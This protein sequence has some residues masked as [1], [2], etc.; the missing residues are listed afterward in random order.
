MTSS[1]T[2]S[3]K[4]RA[5]EMVV[6]DQQMSLLDDADALS[7]RWN[8]EV[9]SKIGSSRETKS[10]SLKQQQLLWGGRGKGGRGIGRNTIQRRDIILPDITLEYISDDVSGAVGSRTLLDGA[11]LKL[12]SGGDR[13]Y[14]LVGRNGC[15]KSTL[16]RRMHAKKIPGFVNL[17]LQSMYIPQEVF[18]YGDHES[19]NGSDNGGDSGQD[20]EDEKE[21]ITPLDVV[22]R[23][24]K[25]NQQ[26]S[27]G[28][29]EKRIET[30]EQELETLMGGNTDDNNDNDDNVD[31][32]D[33]NHEEEIERI[34]NEI[35]MLEDQLNT[36]DGGTEE[37]LD[38]EYHQK[39]SQVLSCFGI[40]EDQQKTSMNYLSG[41]Q[42]KKVLLA[43]TLFCDID[44]LLLDEPTNHLDMQGIV[45]L[46]ALIQ[47]MI[48]RK[49]I[50]VLV[51]HDVALINSVATD[52]IHFANQTLTYYK[53]N[54]TDFLL[55]KNQHDLH[56]VHQQN[57]LNKQRQSMIKTIDNLKKQSIGSKGSGSKKIRRAMNERKKKLERHGVEKDENGHRRTVQSA[58]GIKTASI[59]SLDA[60]TRKH[61]K[62]YSQLIKRSDLSIAPVPE[63]EVQF[64]FKNI[65]C[66]WYEPLVSILD[67]GHGYPDGNQNEA[68]P[69]LRMLF[70]SVDLR[71]DEK[72]TTC[73][74]GENQ[75]GKTTLI[76]LISGEMQPTEGKVQFPSP[77]PTICYFDQH[78]ADNLIV[79]GVTKYGS[80]TSSISLLMSMYPKKTEQDVRGELTAFGL[81]PQQASTHIQFLSGGERCRLCLVMLMLSDP[82]VLI[83]DE[84]S[85][86]LDPES[87][88]ALAYGINNWNGTVVLVSHDIHLIRQIDAKCYVLM[89]EGRLM[90]VQGGID[91]Y[92]QSIWRQEC[93][94]VDV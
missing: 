77:C 51:S 18:G 89:K 52:V 60:S 20:N 81:S 3:S 17:N 2:S 76:R 25:K 92:L 53:G 80:D 24:R 8:D 58:G 85:N 41:G 67:V 1:N 4:N 71:I 31:A 63:K 57:A 43:C 44:V 45:Q 38:L 5:D 12:L 91:S 56:K 55:Q 35:S 22:M 6:V 74:L 78:K 21:V 84:I 36:L 72:S 7:Q 33:E 29:T 68:N 42:K 14:A 16:L 70:D 65:T 9:L 10:L 47:T 75:S 34:C 69:R 87:V 61:A 28:V 79:E 11:K 93:G 13:V 30:L 88:D 62:N 37:G 23:Y 90:C 19:N 73:I 39:A 82:H 86:H 15:G 50:V 83:L 26:E 48:E 27:K 49:A 64:K 94:T 66:H 54:Y 46:H 59:N 40:T 32:N